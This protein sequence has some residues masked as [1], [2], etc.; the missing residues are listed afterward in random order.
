MLYR[1]SKREINQ[2]YLT[3]S[4]Y[5]FSRS[6]AN[7]VNVVYL[8]SSYPIFLSSCHQNSMALF[9]RNPGCVTQLLTVL[10]DL[11]KTLDAGQESVLLY[12]DFSKVFDSVPHNL[13]LDKLLLYG[14]D[15]PLYSWFSDYLH[16]RYQRVHIEGFFSNW[17]NVSSGVPQ[18]GL[19]GPFLFLI[20]INDL[21]KTVSDEAV[22][23]LFADDAKCSRSVNDSSACTN[24]QHDINKLYDW[25]LRW[26]L[27]YNLD[28]C[29]VTRITRKRNSSIR[30][31]A[32][33]MKPEYMPLRSF[34]QKGISE[35][36][37]QTNLHG[38]LTLNAL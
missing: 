33:L 10:H 19:M 4:L 22:I 16:S 5:L 12:L 28:K 32:V 26:G 21:P 30:S 27:A 14:I 8:I 13:L 17:V 23:A 7:C 31:L 20:F 36:S 15:G 18:G 1:S 25:S 24:F 2:W 37:S 11:S 6:S 3:T 9:R 35:L 29:V 38:A 34:P